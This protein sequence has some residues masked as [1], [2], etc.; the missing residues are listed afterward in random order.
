VPNPAVRQSL[1]ELLD[2]FI[3]DLGVE[4]ETLMGT[5]PRVDEVQPFEVGQTFQVFQQGIGDLGD[6]VELQIAEVGRFAVAERVQPGSLVGRGAEDLVVGRH[7][8]A[9]DLAAE[10]N[11]SD[12][13]PLSSHGTKKGLDFGVS[14][15][16]IVGID[17]YDMVRQT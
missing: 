10:S 4:P 9:E 14:R 2:I 6:V 8:D 12:S 13:N 1:L 3:G 17:L 15:I 7:V 5:T 11:D 16:D